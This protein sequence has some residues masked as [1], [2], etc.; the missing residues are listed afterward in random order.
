MKLHL[1]T[2][3]ALALC[4]LFSSPNA[5]AQT[6]T[7]AD[8]LN[9]Q[10]KPAF[11]AGHT[12][13]R[14]TRYGWECLPLVT[15]QPLAKDW[16]YAL[17]FTRYNT[18]MDIV[19]QIDVP[20][21]RESQTVA[22]ALANPQVY[23]LSVCTPQAIP[24]ENAPYEA[25]TRDAAGNILNGQGVSADGTQWGGAGPLISLEA[26][27]S[28]WETTGEFRAAPLRA[29]IARGIPIDNIMNGGESGLGIPGFADAIWNM[30]PV[31]GA[32]IGASPYGSGSMY[33]H[34]SFKKGNSELIIAKITK[35][36]VPGRSF[37][38]Y[39]TA[40]GGTH[41]NK[42]WA[43]DAWGPRWQ[44]TRGTNDIPSNEAYFPGFYLPR[45]R[46]WR[47]AIVQLDQRR[48]GWLRRRQ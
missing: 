29:M 34:A 20:G 28:F 38:N 23:K 4:G 22:L 18:S 24:F 33:N 43:V 40:G 11:K 39:Y 1:H 7:P 14:L 36:A 21:S 32:A 47:H 17:E 3:A 2:V 48:L 46:N 41:R 5:D 9:N 44:H 26:P 25:F 13:P 6:V 15:G 27:D 35:A 8:W 10:P 45:D 31:I 30:D 16:G 42:N 19:A 12:L 37:F